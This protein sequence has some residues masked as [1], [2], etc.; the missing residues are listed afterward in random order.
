M[1]IVADGSS[2]TEYFG[3]A[4]EILI[5]RNNSSYSRSG[6]VFF[7]EMNDCCIYVDEK[8]RPE[9]TKLIH[10]P[11]K[12]VIVIQ[13]HAYILE[14]N[15]FGIITLERNSYNSIIINKLEIVLS[16]ILITGFVGLFGS[17]IYFLKT[18]NL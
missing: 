6:Y 15:Y 8:Y 18:N 1:A 9:T 11:N 10:T 14:I 2:I 5:T 7:G 4:K 17:F 12:I 13:C 16:T 3:E